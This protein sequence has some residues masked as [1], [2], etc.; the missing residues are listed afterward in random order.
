FR[1]PLPVAFFRRGATGARLTYFRLG[2]SSAVLPAPQ[3]R[4]E[5]GAENVFG[6]GFSAV[7][8][9]CDSR[10]CMSLAHGRIFCDP[11]SS[12]SNPNVGVKVNFRA[13]TLLVAIFLAFAQPAAAR[14]ARGALGGAAGGA[15]IGGLAGGGRGAAIGALVGAGTGALIAREG[16]R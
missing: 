13:I 9:V 1:P 14:T 7:M 6:S 15:L 11:V 16:R 8:L 4:R 5:H 12:D 2:R 10:R 3:Q